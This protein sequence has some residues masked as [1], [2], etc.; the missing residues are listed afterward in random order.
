MFISTPVRGYKYIYVCMSVCCG[1]L[2]THWSPS[3]SS[4]RV[5]SYDFPQKAVIVTFKN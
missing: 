3:N 5:I 2:F 1:H 4:R